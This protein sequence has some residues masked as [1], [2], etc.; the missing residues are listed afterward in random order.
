MRFA[1][2]CVL[3]RLTHT[4]P[5]FHYVRVEMSRPKRPNFYKID[6]HP[7]KL[8]QFCRGR[9][10]NPDK[11]S[12]PLPQFRVTS[13]GDDLL[14]VSTPSRTGTRDATE[15]AIRVNHQM[16]ALLIVVFLGAG[17]T[18]GND[19]VAPLPHVLQS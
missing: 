14:P 17:G 5:I 8:R 12:P 16:F 6:Y 7:R 10:P 1:L 18:A 2:V 3:F 4:F 13:Q 11:A 19:P 9:T 15:R